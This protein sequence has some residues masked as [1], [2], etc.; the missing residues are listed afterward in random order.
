MLQIVAHADGRTD[1]S[2][3]PAAPATGAPAPAAP[4]RTPAATRE[5]ARAAA[6]GRAATAGCRCATS[7]AGAKN[8]VNKLSNRLQSGDLECRENGSNCPARSCMCSRTGFVV[9]TT[10]GAVL[11]DLTPHGAEAV[12]AP[13]RSRCGAGRRAKPSELKVTRFACGGDSVTIAY[14]KKHGHDHHPPADPARRPSRRARCR[15]RADGHTTSQAQ[16]TSEIHGRRNGQDYELHVEVGRGEI[17]RR[18]LVGGDHAALRMLASTSADRCRTGGRSRN[19]AG[20]GRIR[21]P[22]RADRSALLRSE[23]DRR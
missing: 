21:S 22:G 17:R 16:A 13:D 2:R 8:A 10:K 3:S 7:A 9:Q 5:A 4:G 15:V 23:E 19:K 14:K 18:R 11:A 12:R 20:F 6:G 1:A